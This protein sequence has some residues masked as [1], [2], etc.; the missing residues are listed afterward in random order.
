MRPLQPLPVI[1]QDSSFHSTPGA[2]PVS[3][4]DSSVTPSEGAAPLIPATRTTTTTT[5]V[6][7]LEIDSGNSR[8]Y[9]ALDTSAAAVSVSS[10]PRFVRRD[11]PFHQSRNE[12]HIAHNHRFK[13]FLLTRRDWFHTLARCSTY[14][15]ACGLLVV[16]TTMIFVFAGIYM[17]MDRRNNEIS[18]GLTADDVPISFG[19]AFAFSLE[20]CTTVGYGLPSSVNSLF[21]TCQALQATVYLQLVWSMLFNAFMFA[22]FYARLGRSESRA[23]QVVFSNKAVVSVQ[24]GLVRFQLRVY[25]LDAQHPVVESHVRLYAIER[26]RP[27]PRPLRLVQPNDEL[28]GV[29]EY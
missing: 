6:T 3:D 25:D 14:F 28:G 18:C 26:L 13:I 11:Q 7:A 1:Y 17:L 20:T 2:A 29:S 23:T 5:T 16:W 22:F 12:I 9:N 21:N 8:T 4:P 10:L 24:D 15:S 27:V 19:A